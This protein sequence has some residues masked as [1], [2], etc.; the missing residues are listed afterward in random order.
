VTYEDVKRHDGARKR[1]W[2]N[3]LV[4]VNGYNY[5]NELRIPLIIG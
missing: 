1:G 2:K 5:K 4:K 3:I